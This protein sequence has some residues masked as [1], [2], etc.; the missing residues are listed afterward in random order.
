[1][2]SEI[3]DR[4]KQN[5]TDT[6]YILKYTNRF[7]VAFGI[8]LLLQFLSAI[9]IGPEIMGLIGQVLMFGGYVYFA[10]HYLISFR[11]LVRSKLDLT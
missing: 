6:Q 5:H 4:I 7:V 1:M 8:S 9:N 10:S 2:N 11:L 3:Y